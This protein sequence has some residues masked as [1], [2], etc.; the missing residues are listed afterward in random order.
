MSNEQ[1]KQKQVLCIS[2]HAWTWVRAEGMKCW[3]QCAWHWLTVSR[4][5]V[6]WCCQRQRAKHVTLA[7]IPSQAERGFM[8]QQGWGIG[9]GATEEVGVWHVRAIQR[10]ADLSRCQRWD[11]HHM[12]W[13]ALFTIHS[14]SSPYLQYHLHTPSSHIA[15]FIVPTFHSCT[16][17]INGSKPFLKQSSCSTH[18]TPSSHGQRLTD[19]AHVSP[20]PTVLR[21]GLLRRFGR[22][23]YVYRIA[24]M[25]FHM[26]PALFWL[27]L[28][29]LLI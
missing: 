27:R 25:A 28:T 15:P 26:F 9:W 22:I 12:V 1:I 4:G 18:C 3:A 7:A 2:N 19:L 14:G 20:L 29:P 16:L 24:R 8:W 21:S 10:G 11:L 5:A 13:N 6:L 23:L 17:V